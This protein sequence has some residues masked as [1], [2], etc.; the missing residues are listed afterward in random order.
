[1]GRASCDNGRYHRHRRPRRVPQLGSPPS[2]PRWRRGPPRPAH[3][4]V[5]YPL[6]QPPQQPPGLLELPPELLLEPQS[7]ELE[8]QRQP[9][10]Q[11]LVVLELEP[12]LVEVSR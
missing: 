4:V 12:L 9:Q 1:M 8:P 11:E 7:L 3:Q 6:P 10:E 2:P 5:A